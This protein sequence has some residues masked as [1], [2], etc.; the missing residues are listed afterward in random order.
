MGIRAIFVIAFSVMSLFSIFNCNIIYKHSK[1]VMQL[2]FSDSNCHCD[3]PLYYIS[4]C[5]SMST[6]ITSSTIVQYVP[7]S[8]SILSI[9]III[10]ITNRATIGKNKCS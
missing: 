8:T 5:T 1:G 4:N 7:M 6:N 2:T 3:C 9:N 10:N